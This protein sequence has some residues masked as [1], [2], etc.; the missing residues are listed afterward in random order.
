MSKHIYI[1]LSNEMN[2]QKKP[3]EM[4]SEELLDEPFKMTEK[5][6]LDEEKDAFQIQYEF[7]ENDKKDDNETSEVI[8]EEES[9]NDVDSHQNDNDVSEEDYGQE[10]ENDY[11]YRMYCGLDDSD[12]EGNCSEENE[13]EGKQHSDIQIYDLSEKEMKD[14]KE[15]K[16]LKNEKKTTEVK[17]SNTHI[18][19]PSKEVKFIDING[20]DEI[21]IEVQYIKKF[22]GF[23][24][25]MD[26]LKTLCWLSFYEN[27]K[28]YKVEKKTN[29]MMIAKCQCCNG[30]IKMESEKNKFNVKIS[31]TE[32]S[33]DHSNTTVEANVHYTHYERIATAK[34][35]I[36]KNLPAVQFK[37]IVEKTLNN[38][39]VSLYGKRV[40]SCELNHSY[41]VEQYVSDLVTINEG[42]VKGK[43]IS[44]EDVENDC[45]VIKSVVITFPICEEMACCNKIIGI[46]ATFNRDHHYTTTIATTVDQN[47]EILCMGLC[48][49][50]EETKSSVSLLLIEMKER[51]ID[52]RF[53]Y[54]SLIFMTDRGI[55]I[56][57]SV[58]EIFPGCLRFNCTW[59]IAKNLL[60][61]LKRQHGISITQ[62]LHECFSAYCNQI[63]LTGS[64]I[65]INRIVVKMAL[66]VQ[67]V[68][69]EVDLLEIESSIIEYLFDHSDPTNWMSMY[70]TNPMRYGYTTSQ[71]A[72]SFNHSIS[73]T[74]KS[75]LLEMIDSIAFKEQQK[76]DNRMNNI[77]KRIDEYG[78]MAIVTKMEREIIDMK[79]NCEVMEKGKIT[80]LNQSK[81][82]SRVESFIVTVDTNRIAIQIFNECDSKLFYCQC[83]V[84]QNKG[85][86]CQHLIYLA[87]SGYILKEEK[88]LEDKIK[89][90]TND[91][92]DV[93]KYIQLYERISFERPSPEDMIES[94]NEYIPLNEV[95]TK[96]KKHSSKEND[97]EIVNMIEKTN[98][99]LNDEMMLMRNDNVQNGKKVLLKQRTHQMKEIAKKK[100]T[101]GEKQHEMTKK[102]EVIEAIKM[103]GIKRHSPFP[104]QSM[105]H[106]TTKV[107][108][109][110]W[111][112]FESF[113]KNG[114]NNI[115]SQQRK[116]YYTN[117]EIGMKSFVDSQTIDYVLSA[118]RKT[119]QHYRI[120][121]IKIFGIVQSGDEFC[122]KCQMGKHYKINKMTK[123]I[124]IPQYVPGVRIGHYILHI[125]DLE[126]QRAV[127]VNSLLGFSSKYT[128]STEFVQ[129]GSTET[130]MNVNQQPSGSLECGYRCLYNC[131]KAIETFIWEKDIMKY[132]HN[133][134]QYEKFKLLVIE[135]HNNAIV[136]SRELNTLAKKENQKK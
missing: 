119:L 118:L 22:I 114:L 4:N 68:N 120:N 21:P 91:S 136:K 134:E 113:M 3:S 52:S 108:E 90:M 74:N 42:R 39:N 102:E 40:L 58:E 101:T 18:P 50:F 96:M 41:S 128:P 67:K 57:I 78:E 99:G 51:F 20:L 124:L 111:N 33:E 61:Y 54:N 66:K 125:V 19:M 63:A 45:V 16:Q 107:I 13:S 14:E 115:L 85:I 27:K 109:Q 81:K 79:R 17:R 31:L 36:E 69:T 38:H 1:D 80:V 133:T 34:S 104:S 72:E 71:F 121:C 87:K 97:Y 76:I 83:S 29:T 59:H 60:D 5:E 116:N 112:I 126:K 110:F 70:S 32:F 84:P 86:P 48:V 75:E 62:G 122:G 23:F 30:Y 10:E 2:Q 94:Y 93:K 47:K 129:S 8:E 131:F 46:D 135:C 15:N 106:G 132:Y 37:E 7:V 56:T 105:K 77:I 25:N 95:K 28:Q 64:L 127:I 98:D 65:T 26:E 100:E 6:R 89:R 49:H 24:R 9:N 35:I 88:S 103:S 123:Y 44:V 11:D 92:I 117:E 82:D 12:N 43:V 53:D 55:S 73:F 130:L